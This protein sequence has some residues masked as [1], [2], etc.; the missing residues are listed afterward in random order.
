MHEECLIGHCELLHCPTKVMLAD[1]LT[2]LASVQV[3]SVLHEAMAGRIPPYKTSNSPG[4]GNPAHTDGDGPSGIRTGVSVNRVGGV[5]VFHELPPK[6]LLV[7]M[8]LIRIMHSWLHWLSSYLRPSKLSKPSRT[9]HHRLGLLTLALCLLVRY[10][11][12]KY[13]TYSIQ[14]RAVERGSQHSR[15]A[16]SDQGR[17]ESTRPQVPG[18]E[19]YHAGGN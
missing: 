4:K 2:K 8:H 7:F 6:V 16:P 15:V 14:S 12:G 11:D 17:E 5:C 13:D 18:V 3:I 10:T 1:A 9:G 19:S